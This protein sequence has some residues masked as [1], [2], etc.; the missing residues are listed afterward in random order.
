MAAL[1]RGV[2]VTVR[3]TDHF[4]QLPI[5]LTPR[6]GSGASEPLAGIVPVQRRDVAAGLLVLIC[7]VVIPIEIEARIRVVRDQAN[8]SACDPF[9]ANSKRAA[10]GMR[11]FVASEKAGLR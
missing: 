8:G 6:I 10:S 2:S 5:G 9:A 1:A 11:I 4:D 7:G 3:R